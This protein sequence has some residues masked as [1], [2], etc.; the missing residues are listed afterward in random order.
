MNPFITF[1]YTPAGSDDTALAIAACRAGGVGVFN[2]ESGTDPGR[3][4]GHLEFISRMTTGEF[5]LKLAFWDERLVPCL[6]EYAQKGLRWLIL[7]AGALSGCLEAVAGLRQNGVHLL[8]ELT[9][10]DWPGHSLETAVD[11]LVLKGNESGGIVGENSS[12][13]LLQKWHRLSRLPV[14]VRGG[15]TPLVAAACNVMGVKGCVLDS[16]VLLLDESPFARDLNPVLGNLSGT[17]TAAIGNSR[18]GRYF[19]FLVRPGYPEAQALCARG[20]CPDT[21][22]LHE[23]ATKHTDWKNPRHSLLPIGQDICF[24]G[25]WKKRYGHMAGVIRAIQSAVSERVH[26]ME[27]GMS[28]LEHSS[29]PQTLGTSLPL[30]QGPMARVSDCP[31]FAKAVFHGGALPVMALSLLKGSAL[32]A[33]MENTATVFGDNAWGVGFLGFAP[34]ELLDEQLALAKKYRPRV[35]VIAGGR[36]DQVATFEKAGLISFMHVPSADLLPLFLQEGA[37]RFIFEGRECGGHIGPLSGFVLW[38]SMVASLLSELA[39]G[40][41]RG[42]EIQVLFAGGIHDAFSS[43]M[44]QALAAP[45]VDKGVSIGLLMGSAYLFSKEI[46]E[47]GAVVPGFQK[48]VIRCSHT[49]TLESAPGHVSRCSYTDFAKHFLQERRNLFRKNVPAHTIRHI[50]DELVMG[51]LRIAAKGCD[52]CNG[53]MTLTAFD[54]NH[55]QREG[56][57]M[58]GQLATL[59]FDTTDIATL[60]QDVTTNAGRLLS[61]RIN[62]RETVRAGSEGPPAD[63]AIVG[64][65]SVMPKSTVSRKF[66]EN[67]LL[68]VDAISEIPPHRWDW[69]LYFDKDR[70]ARDKIYSRWGG[71]MEDMVFDPTKYGIPPKSI[72]TVDPMQLMA[73]DVARQSME[74]AG[75]MDR[76]FDRET[77]SVII[78]NSGSGD[79]GI[80]Y[81]LRAEMPRFTGGLPE[82]AAQRLPEWSED[83]FAGILSNV[84]AGRIANRLNLGGTNYSIDAA[85]ASSMAAVCH[86]VNE[87]SSGRSSLVIAG[88]VDTVQSPFSYLCF[89]KTQALSPRGRCDVFDTASDGIVLSE[90]IAMVVLKRLEDAERDGDRIYAVIKGVGSSSDGRAMGLTA[91]LP[92]GQ[93]LCMRRA[94]EQAGFTPDTIGMFEAHGTGTAAGDTAE[95]ESTTRLIREAGAGP[96]QAMIGSVKTLIGHTKS[97]AGI[98]GLIKAALALHHRVLPPHGEVREPYPMLR[99]PDSPLYLTDEALPWLSTENRPRRAA[100]SAFGFGG[101]NFHVVLEEYMSE[102]RPWMRS[103]VSHD[104]PSELL[105]WSGPDRK[106]LAG[107]LKDLQRQ[108]E[109]KPAVELRDLAY[110][111]A[112]RWKKGMETIAM[113]AGDLTDLR[114]KIDRTLSC[115][116][117]QTPSL[118]PGVYHG[119]GA[120]GDGRTAVL[121]SGQGAQHTGML[122]ELAVHFPVMSETLS[123]ADALLGACFDKRFGNGKRLSHFIYPRGAYDDQARADAAKALT[124]T[125]VAQPALGAVEAGL[126]R[127][128]RSLG[129]APHMLAGHSYGEFAA[130]FAGGV[131]DFKALMALSEAR[132]RFIADTA[133]KAGADL[134]KMVAVNASR[135]HVEK[136]IAGMDG[137]YLANINAPRQI[138]VSGETSAVGKA[139]EKMSEHKV[140]VTEIPVQAA[141]HSPLVAPAQSALADLIEKTGW[142]DCKIP[143]YSNTT[144]KQHA[145]KIPELKRVMIDHLVK[146]VEFLKQI[147]TMYDDGARIFVE[148]G[149]KSILTGLVRRILGDRPHKA[150][151]IDGHGGGI[152]GLLNT[153]GQ[154]LCAGTDMN[155]VTLFDGR[156]CMSGD[157]GQL[158]GLQ[159]TPAV[160]K[161]AWLLN[162]SHARR[163]AAPVR[164]TVPRNGAAASGKAA[165]SQMSRVLKP[166]T[167]QKETLPMGINNHPPAAGDSAVMAAY[168]DMMRQFLDTQERVMSSYMTGRPMSRA[169]VPLPARQNRHQT[170]QRHAGPERSGPPQPAP[171]PAGLPIQP[172]A[173]GAQVEEPPQVEEAPPVSENHGEPVNNAQTQAMDRE[174][175]TDLLLSIVEDKTGYPRELI[176]LNQKL[177]TD[178]GIDSIKRTQV[179]GAV[180]K[181][182]PPHFTQLL[183][184]E[185]RTRLSTQATLDG[186]LDLLCR[187]CLEGETPPPFPEAG[188][189]STGC[190]PTPPFRHVIEPE[191]ERIDDAALRNPLQGHFILTQDCLGVAQ[192]LSEL[193]EARGCTISM[194]PRDALMEETS[195][196]QWCDSAEGHMEAVAGVVHLGQIG[197]GRIRAE[198]AV[199]DW[200]RQLQCS[201]KSFFL[202]LNRFSGKINDNGHVL[203][204]SSLGGFFSRKSAADSGLLL[205]GGTVGLLKSLLEERPGLR[206]KAVDLDPGQPAKD[207][208][209]CL[210]DEL[211]LAGG[212]QEVG[213]PE[214]VRTVFRTIPRELKKTGTSPDTLRNSVVLAT[215]GAKG[216]TA[217]LLRELALPGNTLVL[218]GRS[219]LPDSEP[220]AVA[221]MT[222]PALL[223]DHFISEVRNGR[224]NLTPAQIGRK[225]REILSCREMR[226]NITDFETR[227]ATVEYHA[228]DAADDAAMHRLLDDIYQRHGKISGVVHGAGII[229]DRFLADKTG[230]SWSRVVETKVMGLLILQKYL[231]RE[232][233]EFF[234]VLSSVAGRYGNSGQ[235][236]YATANELMNRLC[237]QLYRAWGEKVRFRAFCWGPWDAT[238]FG[239]GMVTP[240]TEA[241]FAEKGVR[242]VSTHAGRALF[243]DELVHG[244]GDPVEI[245]CGEGPWEEVEAIRGKIQKKPAP[246]TDNRPGPLIDNAAVTAAPDGTYTVAFS[247]GNNHAY[248]QEHYIDEVPVLPAA[249]ALEIMAEAAAHIWPDQFVVEARDC[250]LLNGIQVKEQTVNLGVVLVPEPCGSGVQVHATL[251]SK[252]IRGIG[253]AHYRCVLHLDRQIPKGFQRDTVSHD[254]KKLSVEKAYNEWLFHGPRFQV[255]RKIHGLSEKGARVSLRSSLPEQWVLN[256][257]NGRNRWVF[258]PAVVDAAAQTALLWTRSFCG[259][260]ALPAGYG[261]VV[262]YCEDLPE[263]VYMQFE[264][265]ADDAFHSVIANVYFSDENNHVVLLI[266]DMECI[267]SA[268]LNRLGGSF[269]KPGRTPRTDP[270]DTG[271][272]REVIYGKGK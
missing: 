264:K 242:L 12:F 13:I 96:H 49:V 149:P 14:F 222:T 262:R 244:T 131:F 48:E 86:G 145:E 252:Q 94:Y 221:P 253:P 267:S 8:A 39:D 212:R 193:L 160:P 4:P 26:Q 268:A 21:A 155:P 55:Q 101:T 194:V 108:L 69:R 43:A 68:K 46:V 208:A 15:V 38:S 190:K 259:E 67:I 163:A 81:G 166:E 117:A 211:A 265:T 232:S 125:D 204:A 180:L 271:K 148:L 103:A 220:E 134:G 168:F 143:V 42:E 270:G 239:A 251:V 261:R 84:V 130:L 29:V 169:S 129:F 9:T 140:G 54:E 246:E 207:L 196:K 109:K 141:F 40:T 30:V 121:F 44:V 224:L 135:E 85:C 83:T 65:A 171:Q 214:G 255:I 234:T 1:V 266:E 34:Q 110:S 118:P 28:L 254:E 157:P 227:G 61:E 33:V 89:S 19:R 17:E 97:T 22:D 257:G 153:I 175:L 59:R 27:Q 213:Y 200:Q 192:E 18:E 137:V 206:V 25:R 202:L 209:G 195:L 88:G 156:D 230:E 107:Q 238:T 150:V 199:A 102:Y 113:V 6:T 151:A 218:T 36:P 11:G 191:P 170:F 56:M 66:W 147:E 119:D 126:W 51:K 60:H 31:E 176:A 71:F 158:A 260:S 90:G 70:H 177:E 146:P 249:A 240:E 167:D 41:L 127:L 183:G 53:D 114:T 263:T 185:D 162:G 77:A 223:R 106:T 75:Y 217:E 35:A 112:G 87:L 98:A 73:L 64:I 225:I 74:D 248:L 24:A 182:L 247:L 62:G 45:L 32:N 23:L 189:E 99:K 57:Y 201:E 250:R 237:C 104:W 159:R 138:I 241:K 179:V 226:S 115:L 47:T 3:I 92:E 235:S 210:I 136:M 187:V 174:K 122:R 219:P 269:G 120:G 105:L 78:G 243:R 152:T 116:D 133:G 154:L 79:V 272:E 172:E 52:R 72:E 161:H 144:G 228:V 197:S 205:Q 123:E 20:E 178:L 139:V 58:V 188:M 124:G 63:I 16:Q 233:L 80:Q 181:A 93:L 2:A 256:A 10:P 7:D 231:R 50:L 215:G 186:M 132:G 203:S 236:D 142:Q 245:V 258:D 91:P 82:S 95:L 164:Q 216:V 173:I 76:P 37:R 128:M 100:A 111:L 198:A 5:G 184:E 229:E 165:G